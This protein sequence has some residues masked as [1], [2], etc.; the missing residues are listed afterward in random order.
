MDPQ[1]AAIAEPA[2]KKAAAASRQRDP[3]AITPFVSSE[4]VP[5][6]NF[7]REQ[8]LPA[9]EDVLQACMCAQVGHVA[10]KPAGI[11][12]PPAA[13]RWRSA[14]RADADAREYSSA[15]QRAA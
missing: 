1:P 2:R 10:M 13:D 6:G 7:G 8:R 4:A 15:R 12:Q 11:L 5:S 14:D 3:R 9:R